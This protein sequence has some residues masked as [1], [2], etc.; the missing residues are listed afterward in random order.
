MQ[1]MHH[2]SQSRTRTLEATRH[3]KTT[4]TLCLYQSSLRE[5]MP[6]GRNGFLAVDDV[7]PAGLGSLRI[8]AAYLF[9]TCRARGTVTLTLSF[10]LN[11][12]DPIGL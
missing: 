7:F 3:N 12:S 6:K 1:L 4:D 8:D 5:E 11:I 2:R 9:N 10:L